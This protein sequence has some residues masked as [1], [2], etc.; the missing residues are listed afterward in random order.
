M[1]QYAELF[2][3]TF[4]A[5]FLEASP[6]LVLGALLSTL[7][8]IYLPDDFIGKYLP[9]GRLLGLLVGLVPGS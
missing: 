4:I 1:N 9:R 6:F 7:V 8:E 5:V 3:S 2:S